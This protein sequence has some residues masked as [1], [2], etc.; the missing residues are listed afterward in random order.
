MNSNL[1]ISESKP[2]SHPEEAADYALDLTRAG[3]LEQKPK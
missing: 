3:I 1:W 2:Q